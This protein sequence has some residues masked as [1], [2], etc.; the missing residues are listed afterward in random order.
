MFTSHGI[1]DGAVRSSS[2]ASSW[3]EERRTGTS[4]GGM[5][6]GVLE[7]VGSLL[8]RVPPRQRQDRLVGGDEVGHPGDGADDECLPGRVQVR[9][10]PRQHP[11]ARQLHTNINSRSIST[12]AFDY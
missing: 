2:N 1:D 3:P 9:L 6:G 11:H 8:V 10:R 7:V 5:E 4:G 12:P